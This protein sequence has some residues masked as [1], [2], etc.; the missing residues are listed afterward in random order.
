MTGLEPL[1]GKPAAEVVPQLVHQHRRGNRGVVAEPSPG[2][3]HEEASP[4]REERLQEREP[5]LAPDVAVAPPGASG[6]DEVERRGGRRARKHAVVHAGDADDPG[7]KDPA[8]AQAGHAHPVGQPCRV[9]GGVAGPLAK[10]VQHHFE[11]HRC[12]GIRRFVLEVPD[13]RAHR[14]RFLPQL[15]GERPAVGLV[16]AAHP[17]RAVGEKVADHVAKHRTPSRRLPPSAEPVAEL[18]HPLAVRDEPSEE[19]AVHLRELERP[20]SGPTGYEPRDRLGGIRHRVAEQ[21][22]SQAVPPGVIGG[23]RQVFLAPVRRVHAPADAGFA[24]PFTDRGDLGA[25]D[26]EPRSDCR[27]RKRPEHRL[28]AVARCREGQEIEE[29]AQRARLR[30][31]RAGDVARDAPR[32]GEDG[33]DGGPVGFQVRRQH[34]NV[35]GLEVRMGIE[36][37]EQ[38]VVQH[39]RLPH[40]RVADVDLERIVRPGCPGLRRPGLSIRPRDGAGRRPDPWSR[41]RQRAGGSPDI[42]IGC[43][44]RVHRCRIVP[45]RFLREPEV[46]DVALHRGETAG[47]RGLHEAFLPLR[48]RHLDQGVDHVASRPAPGREQLVALGEVAG[49]GVRAFGPAVDLASRVDV[50]PVLAA[51]VEHEEVDLDTAGHLAEKLQVGRRKRRHREEAGAARPAGRPRRVLDA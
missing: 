36:D 3:G 43:A 30:R 51:R 27:R 48:A 46:E 15:A 17:L 31:P 6:R 19:L 39:L 7:G 10:H 24:H 23:L 49:I 37:G 44:E 13:E 45:R 42:R 41:L 11:R 28:R 22:A 33:L 47:A 20:L 2:V 38:A 25:T 21:E 32:G 35:G 16:R 26:P 14:R 8:R 1:A 9:A 12:P 34:E 5:I 50:A 18:E 4:R 40:R 29:C